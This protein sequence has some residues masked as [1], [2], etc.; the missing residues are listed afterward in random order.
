MS[1]KYVLLEKGNPGKPEEP[2]KW[3]AAVKS[4]GDVSLRAIGKE[5][6]QRSTVNYAIP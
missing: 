6:A 1:V 2:K 4:A 3:Y 5:I